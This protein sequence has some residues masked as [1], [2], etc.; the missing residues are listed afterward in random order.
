M[1][2]KLNS[3]INVFPEIFEEC[4]DSIR[5]S[6]SKLKN[7]SVK[8]GFIDKHL[9]LLS[10]DYSDAAIGEFIL[11]SDLVKSKQYF[12][13]SGKIQEYLFLR[14]DDKSIKVSPSFVTMN[15][16][17]K[18]LIALISDDDMLVNS[19]AKLIGDRN[20]EELNNGHPFTNNVGYIIKYIIL[21]DYNSA[22]E[23][24]DFLE[25]DEVPNNEIF[26]RNYHRILKGIL[27]KDAD[28]VDKGLQSMLVDYKKMKAFKDSPEELFCIPVVGLA[29]LADRQGI[30]VT[31]D[32]PIVPRVMLD[33][34]NIIYP[35]FN[36]F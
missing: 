29:K 16:Y 15:K 24:V 27:E 30:S 21:K 7:K 2:K 5:N 19:L 22:K 17:F 6:Q 20:E 1:S 18:I 8:E 10:L 13:L 9:D 28:S 14:Y 32:D 31:I 36:L 3:Y 4:I 26:Y 35:E 11:N 33:K 23:R 12:Y 34:Q 25:K